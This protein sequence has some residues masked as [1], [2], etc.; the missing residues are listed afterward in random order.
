MNGPDNRVGHALSRHLPEIAKALKEIG[1]DIREMRQMFEELADKCKVCGG[2]EGFHTDEC[3]EGVCR[4][5]GGGVVS[6]HLPQ[7]SKY[8]D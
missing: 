2:L 5:C 1:S 6:P 3:T 8:D 7:C 4:E